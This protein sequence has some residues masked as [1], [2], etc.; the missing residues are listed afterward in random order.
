MSI[1]SYSSKIY[2]VLTD[3]KI[4]DQAYCCKWM[5][6]DVICSKEIK[7]SDR[8]GQGGSGYDHQEDT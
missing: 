3:I 8:Y 5:R 7:T 6:Y 4:T 2:P 1:W